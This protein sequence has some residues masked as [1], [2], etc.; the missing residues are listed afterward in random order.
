MAHE[1]A[2]LHEEDTAYLHHVLIRSHV[3]PRHVLEDAFSDPVY[4]VTL[5]QFGVV[6][7]QG[8]KAGVPLR[9]WLLGEVVDHPGGTEK[10]LEL[11]QV[12]VPH[13]NRVVLVDQ[14]HNIGGVV[15]HRG[16]RGLEEVADFFGEVL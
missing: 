3:D 4:L 2:A 12:L 5:A 11:I 13:P 16:V 9:Q 7:T 6:L 1:I 8:M 10:P 14:V 15:Q